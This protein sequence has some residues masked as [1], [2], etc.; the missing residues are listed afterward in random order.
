L[1][2]AP[3]IGAS[4]ITPMPSA[5]PIAKAAQSL[6]ARGWT[7]TP[8]IAQ[9]KKNVPSASTTMPGK[10]APSTTFVTAGAP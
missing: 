3:V 4:T 7:A 5:P 2:P 1:K 10:A 9:S 6:A 8:M